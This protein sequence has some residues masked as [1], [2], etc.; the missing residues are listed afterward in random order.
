MREKKNLDEEE[1]RRED[2]PTRKGTNGKVKGQKE[3]RKREDLPG[4]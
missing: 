1:R 3:K 4:E 2:K